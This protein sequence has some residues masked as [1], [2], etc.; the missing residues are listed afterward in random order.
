MFRKNYLIGF[1]TI[2]L[3]LI[4]SATVFAQTAPLRG[5]VVLKGA[6]GKLTPIAGAQVDVL[7]TDTNAKFFSTTTDKKGNFAFAGVQLGPVFALSISASGANPEIIPNIKAGRE[8]LII[9]LL[10]GDG[11]RYTEED[12][13]AGLANMNGGGNTQNAQAE[14]DAKKQKEEYDKKLAEVNAKN[15]KIKNQTAAVQKAL[16][17][18]NAAFN[19]KNYD[20]AV[21]KYEEGF[22]ANPDFV[23]SAPVLLNN[24]GAALKSRAVT[25]YNANVK[26]TDAAAKNAAMAK[27][28][29]DL[30]DA[31]EAYN[32]SWTI[33]KNAPT[34]DINDPK[35]HELNK[36]NALNGAKDTFRLMSVTRLVDTTKADIAKSLIS[37][38][39]AIEADQ[40]K[41]TE[42]QRI[43][44][45]IYLAAGDS[46]NAIIE[47]KRVLDI[48]PS[49]PDS[50]V[51]IGLSL[52]TLGYTNND[53]TKM[54][55]GADYLQRFI[56]VAPPNHKF[57][58]D[59]KNTIAQLKA[60]QN[61]AP[62]KGKTTTTTKKK[63]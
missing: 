18:G 8:D 49:D 51:G 30:A 19:S 32:K 35:T 60:E 16:D 28:Q 4:G 54:Q 39:V 57:L 21:V 13:R 47:Y 23:G 42:A 24:K 22:Q 45:D 55:E 44:G 61:V 2:A 17:E 50:L 6:D 34:T 10:P 9:N 11:K 59:A 5:R 25:V 20:V 3:F 56:D 26:S 41:K 31:V 48:N 15:E 14:A 53:K 36:L 58:D 43:L 29:Q 38:Y 52:I 37:E 40:A 1:L 62:Q 7:R 46:E 27:V 33:L 63:N 12:V